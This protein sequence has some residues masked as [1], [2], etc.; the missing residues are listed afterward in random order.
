MILLAAIAVGVFC[1]CLAG[2]LAGRTPRVRGWRRPRP[3]VNAQQLW[4]TQAGVRL[5][6]AQFWFTSLLLGVAAFI[7]GWLVTQTPLIALV[8]GAVAALLP[9]AFYAQRRATRLRAVQEA[10][11]DGLRDLV[12]SISAGRSL[13][14]ALISLASSGP[15]PLQ[16]AFARFP[17][18][19]RVLGTAAALEVV[20]E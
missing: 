17:A 5:T 7:A 20:K 10:W 14:Q 2:T 15:A 9:R 16:I 6:P 12:A 13:T 18:L 19:S 4:L 8:P 11:P 1:Y 3:A